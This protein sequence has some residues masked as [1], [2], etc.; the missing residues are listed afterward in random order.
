MVHY[1]FGILVDFSNY[2]API[3]FQAHD[4]FSTRKIVLHSDLMVGTPI[5]FCVQVVASLIFGFGLDWKA[6]GVGLAVIVGAISGLINFTS[7]Q[8]LPK[9]T[10]GAIDK[11]ASAN[12]IR[13]GGGRVVKPDHY[14]VM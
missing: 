9:N 1:A 6:A 7:K 4:V 8:Y 14:N 11:G 10:E 3:S 2:Q 12:Y 5:W 13:R